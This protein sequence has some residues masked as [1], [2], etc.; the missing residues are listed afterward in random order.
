MNSFA[1]DQL[2]VQLGYQFID[3]SHLELALTHPSFF[4]EQVQMAGD[5]QRLEFL[6]DAIL[7]MLLAEILYARFP[8]AEEGELSRSRAQLAGQ[9]SLAGTARAMGLGDYIRLGKGELLTAGRDK[10]SILA[11]IVES[12][13]A[14]VYLDGGLDAARRLVVLL[15][16]DL[17]TISCDQV[18]AR[19]P[20]SELQELLSARGMEPPEYRLAE[21]SGPPHDRRFTYLVLING[22]V[23]GEGSGRSK[24]IA[25]QSAAVQALDVLS[26]SGD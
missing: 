11:D 10:D 5:Y 20:K 7:G 6:G 22:S 13:I 24:K 4:N 21:E 18:S 2:E 16:D 3:R 14:A 15:F 17:L 25:Q 26:G 1:L 8:E 23:A 9:G 12:L 19:D